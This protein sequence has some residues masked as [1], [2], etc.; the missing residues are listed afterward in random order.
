[1]DG[2]KSN[3][4]VEEQEGGEAGAPEK[5]ATEEIE[6]VSFFKLFRYPKGMHCPERFNAFKGFMHAHGG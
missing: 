1:M 6:P 4:V 5:V 2:K 3:K